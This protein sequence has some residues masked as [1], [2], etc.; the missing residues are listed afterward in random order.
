MKDSK[1]EC[2]GQAAFDQ[3]PE[4]GI[5]LWKISFDKNKNGIRSRLL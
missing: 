5:G 1:D 4:T 3:K 2:A